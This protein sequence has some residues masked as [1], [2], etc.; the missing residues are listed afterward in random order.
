MNKFSVCC[1]EAQFHVFD[2]RTQHPAKVWKALPI[3]FLQSGVMV[4]IPPP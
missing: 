1:L 3:G 4:L 2:A